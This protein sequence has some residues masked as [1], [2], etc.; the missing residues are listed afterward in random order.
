MVSSNVSVATYLYHQ[1]TKLPWCDIYRP[2]NII[3]RS[4]D[5]N[6]SF[7][8]VLNFRYRAGHSQGIRRG[9]ETDININ[10]KNC[11]ARASQLSFSIKNK[12][13]FYLCIC[14]VSV[15]NLCTCG[16]AIHCEQVG[17][18]SEALCKQS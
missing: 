10:F 7:V 18:A 3:F 4:R 16:F 17:N 6:I 9:T 5:E 11:K 8:H 15:P 14:L 13:N 1:E 2:P 12:V